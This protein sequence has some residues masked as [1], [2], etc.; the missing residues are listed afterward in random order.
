[1]RGTDKLATHDSLGRNGTLDLE[2]V[3]KDLEIALQSESHAIMTVGA[4]PALKPHTP[5]FGCF[6]KDMVSDIEQQ[7]SSAGGRPACDGKAL[8]DLRLEGL[9]LLV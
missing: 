9:E 5:H 2:V 1:V 6:G 7:D 4:R 3:T 8:T